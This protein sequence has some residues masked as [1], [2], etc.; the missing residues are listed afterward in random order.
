MG[1][2]VGESSALGLEMMLSTC[3]SADAGTD[4]ENKGIVGVPRFPEDDM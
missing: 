3:W 2:K 4:W 1:R